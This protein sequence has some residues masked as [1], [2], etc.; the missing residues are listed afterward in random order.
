[1]NLRAAFSAVFCLTL[2]SC[3]YSVDRVWVHG[4]QVGSAPKD[5]REKFSNTLRECV[6]AFDPT[7]LP[8]LD[9]GDDYRDRLSGWFAGREET[10]P[11]MQC[12]RS[13]DWIALPA[14]LFS[15]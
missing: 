4:E 13:K 11:V 12:M 9:K 2:S 10:Q 1:M 15:P 6:T 8:K 5:G 7:Y 14:Y 3:V